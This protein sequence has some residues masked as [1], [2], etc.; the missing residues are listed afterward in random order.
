METLETHIQ[1]GI[2]HIT[3]N[4]EKKMNALNRTVIREIGEAVQAGL[5]N[6]EVYGM[7]LTG[8]GDKAF[9]AGADIAEFSSYS[10]EEALEMTQAGHRVFDSIEACTKPVIAAVN[11]FALG[12]GCELAMACH[13]R[14]ASE[15]ARFGQP[16]VNLGLVPGYGGT[17]RL[18]QLIGRGRALEFLMT[19][20]M[21]KAQQ[22]LELGL[23]NHVV[24]QEDVLEK[25]R[26]ILGKIRS[27]A[28][29]AIGRTIKLVNDHYDKQTDSFREEQ[30]EFANS[31]STTDFKEG[32]DAFLNKRRANFQG[33]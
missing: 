3:I 22:A 17:Q 23:V 19:G 32:V 26:E 9:A 27:K 6:E 28:P 29:L 20:D 15:N 7:I 21:I 8:K 33:K 12:G 16:E 13:L 25:S 18:P 24:S 4:R 2:L 30:Q 10:R 1:E 31:F 11:G 5:E 14:I